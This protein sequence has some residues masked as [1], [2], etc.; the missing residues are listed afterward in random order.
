MEAEASKDELPPLESVSKTVADI[1]ADHVAEEYAIE[2][3]PALESTTGATANATSN[4][5][6]EDTLS[7]DSRESDADFSPEKD[8]TELI[9]R[10][11]FLKEEGNAHF[12]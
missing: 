2:E 5:L 8:P 10:A 1:A 9:V 12:K 6:D 3:P 11:T 4:T 7:I